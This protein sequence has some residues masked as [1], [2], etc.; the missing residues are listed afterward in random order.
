[1]VSSTWLRIC[2]TRPAIASLRVSSSESVGCSY[3]PSFDCR[4]TRFE[5]T[6]AAS[7]DTGLLVD[8]ELPDEPGQ[9]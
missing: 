8:L 4:F 6:E 5:I 1:M 9:P 3:D 7:A 2:L